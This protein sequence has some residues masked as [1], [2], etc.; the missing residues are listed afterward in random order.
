MFFDILFT[1]FH[2]IFVSRWMTTHVA[3]VEVLVGQMLMGMGILVLI[4]VAVIGG[5]KRWQT[6]Q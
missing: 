3:D 1:H 2:F 5:I 6:K 4:L